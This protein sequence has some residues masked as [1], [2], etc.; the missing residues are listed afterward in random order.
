MG[1][2][3]AMRA[4]V[5]PWPAPWLA[6]GMIL[7]LAGSARAA[8]PRGEAKARFGAGMKA[9]DH[10]DNEGALKE[11]EAAYALV[12][13]PKIQFNMGIA[14]QALGHN[15]L[16]LEAFDTFLAA[17]TDDIPQEKRDQASKHR[18]ELL[19][20]VATITITCDQPGI[21]VSLD[22]VVQGKTPFN[23]P[24]Y[25]EPGAHRL[26]AEAPGQPSTRQTF[27]ASRGTELSIPI[28]L[29]APPAPGPS[30]KALAASTAGEPA[31]PAGSTTAKPSRVA[32]SHPIDLEARPI[33]EP[34]QIIESRPA[35]P[36]K[37]GAWRGPVKWGSFGLAVAGVGLGVFE[38]LAAIKKSKDFNTAASGSCMDDG[39]GDIRGGTVCQQIAHDQTVATWAAAI[40]YGLAGAFATTGLILQFSEPAAES[41]SARPWPRRL[42][43]G[44]D[45]SLTGATCVARW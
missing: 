36:P 3:K 41:A 26:V 37:P 42:A 43:C 8:N 31:S 16:A 2:R 33:D 28:S 12:P 17:A 15:V 25:A 20:K 40:S 18:Q 9:L 6:L 34:P 38:T 39:K 1:A 22:G 32:Q 35:P 29:A 10:G 7:A 4:S 21:T 24:I 27:A 19:A 30:S 23:G 14:H 13:S 45:G 5:E 11:F 44:L